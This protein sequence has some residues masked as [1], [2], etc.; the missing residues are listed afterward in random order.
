[1]GRVLGPDGDGGREQGLPAVVRAAPLPG[2]DRGRGL[3]VLFSWF[4]REAYDGRP[5]TAAEVTTYVQ[6]WVGFGPWIAF[7]VA[8]MMERVGLMAVRFDLGT[9]MYAGSPTEATAVMRDWENPGWEP[10]SQAELSGWAVGA[11]L[12]SPELSGRPAPPRNDRRLGFQEAETIL[13]KWKSYLG[14]HYH[15]GE[16][17]AAVRAALVRFARVPLSQKLLRAGKRAGLWS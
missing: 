16:D 10:D 8:D 2:G 12:A 14:G 6:T 9:A 13:C 15:V 5:L 1:V 17:V 7:K 3:D 4:D 11:L